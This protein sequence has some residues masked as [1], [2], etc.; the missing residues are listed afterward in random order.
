MAVAAITDRRIKS[1]LTGMSIIE[2][3]TGNCLVFNRPNGVT[4]QTGIEERISETVSQLGERVIETVD[5]DAFQ[6]VLQCNFPGWTPEGIAMRLGRKLE[7]GSKT[8]YYQKTFRVTAANQVQTAAGVGEEGNG[9]AADEAGSKASY[10]ADLGISTPLSRVAVATFDPAVDLLSYSVGAD[11]ALS[12]SDDLIGATVSI[13]IPYTVATTQYIGEGA[14]LEFEIFLTYIMRDLKIFQVRIPSATISL[15]DGDID[16]GAA[17][18]PINFRI[19][20]DGSTCTPIEWQWI[21][22]ARAC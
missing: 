15:G 13:S 18:A 2:K 3:S 22:Q 1:N 19:T 16:L 12:F 5:I 4:I 10:L 7:T 6:P 21:D 9:I 11:G 14:F 20:Y 8:L 17:E